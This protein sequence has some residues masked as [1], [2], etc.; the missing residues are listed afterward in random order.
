MLFVLE[1]KKCSSEKKRPMPIRNRDALRYKIY[2]KEPA[3][4]ISHQLFS[5][6]Q[7]L[8]DS[9]RFHSCPVRPVQ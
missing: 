8:S 6:I 1:P 3:Q 9:V 5:D 7:R 2:R 4:K